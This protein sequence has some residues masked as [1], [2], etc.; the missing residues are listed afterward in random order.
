MRPPELAGAHGFATAVRLR[1]AQFHRKRKHQSVVIQYRCHH[2]RMGVGPWRKAHIVGEPGTFGSVTFF[3][4]PTGLL[5]TSSH[6]T[7]RRLQTKLLPSVTCTRRDHME[8]E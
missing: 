7:W 6:L 2:K 3:G 5:L 8:S 1:I 4:E